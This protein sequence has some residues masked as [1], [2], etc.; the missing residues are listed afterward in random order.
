MRKLFVACLWLGCSDPKPPPTPQEPTE[1]DKQAP[2]IT[3][4]GIGEG[5]VTQA[6][7]TLTFSAADDHLKSVQGLLNGV[8]FASGSTVEREEDYTLVVDAVDASNNRSQGQRRFAIDRTAPVVRVSRPTAHAVYR[9][10]V[11][12]AYSVEEQHPKSTTLTWNGA[13]HT[14]PVTSEGDHVIRVA[15][16]DQAGNAAE[17]S[18]AFA[19][20]KTAPTLTVI[21]PP[22]GLAVASDSIQVLVRATDNRAVA[23]V[24]AG[25]IALALVGDQYAG[26][27]PLGLGRNSI[28]IVASD[29]AGNESSVSLIVVRAEAPAPEEDESAAPTLHV[30]LPAGGAI[31]R[32]VEVSGRVA[33]GTPPLVVTVNGAAAALTG[34]SF[35]H[36]LVATDGEATL[37]L[38]VTDARARSDRRTLTVVVDKTAPVITVTA[39]AENP[40]EIRLT[41]VVL[42]GTVVDTHLADFRIDGSPVVIS[43]LSTFS[44][45][46]DLAPGTRT[47]VLLARDAAGNKTTYSQVLHLEGRTPTVLLLSPFDGSESP[48]DRVEVRVRVASVASI[49]SVTM[50]GVTAVASGDTYVATVPL[51]LGDNEVEV[52]ATDI[53]GMVGALL[54][55]VHYSDAAVAPLAVKAV[56]P[57]QGSEGVAPGAT[58]ALTFNKPIE[59]SG[60]AAAISV[61][62]QGAPIA[63][64]L[65]VP[66]EGTFVTFS[67]QVPLPASGRVTVRV[68]ETL[69]AMTGPGLAAEFVSEFSVRQALTLLQGAMVTAEM[70]PIA[71][72][73]VTLAGQS[74]QTDRN[75][76]WIAVGAAGDQ[77]LTY[78]VDDQHHAF[79]RK[80]YVPLAETTRLRP[81]IMT[82]IDSAN[83]AHAAPGA[84][85]TFADALALDGSVVF[86]DGTSSGTL[87][88]TRLQELEVPFPVYPPLGGHRI[89]QLHPA[90][91]RADGPVTISFPADAEV[92]AGGRILILAL[93]PDPLVIKAI[94]LGTE[95]DGAIRSDE[96][97]ATPSLEAIG[98]IPLSEKAALLLQGAVPGDSEGALTPS[99]LRRMLG[100]VVKDAYAQEDGRE[101]ALLRFMTYGGAS[102]APIFA[103]LQSLLKIESPS[104][105]SGTV[106]AVETSFV[107]QRFTAPD[108]SRGAHVQ[109]GVTLPYSLRI[110]FAS[111]FVPSDP[112]TSLRADL[113]LWDPRGQP[114]APPAGQQWSVAGQEP[115]IDAIVTLAQAGTYRMSV[116]AEPE[117]RTRRAKMTGREY[118]IHVT[119]SA[120][121]TYRLVVA[122]APGQPLRSACSN[123]I[124][125]DLDGQSDMA[126]DGCQGPEDT[127]ES[128]LGFENIR[129]ELFSFVPDLWDATDAYG[130]YA[131]ATRIPSDDVT[132]GLVVAEFPLGLLNYEYRANDG[133][134][135]RAGFAPAYHFAKSDTFLLPP[136]AHTVANI[137]VD[138]RL[139][140]GSLVFVD[141]D[142]K[143]LPRFLTANMPATRYVDGELTEISAEDAK[144]TEIWFFRHRDLSQPILPFSVLATNIDA[145]GGPDSHG[146]YA[147]L[148]LGPGDIATWRRQ[149]KTETANT[150]DTRVLTEGERLVVF[151]VNH[152]TGH[153]GMSETVVPPPTQ[154][155]INA[156]V[157][158]YPPEVE[159]HIERGIR[160]GASAVTRQLVRHGGQ[161]T[162]RDAYVKVAT[163]WRVRWPGPTGY[164]DYRHNPQCTRVSEP[165]DLPLDTYGFPRPIG[166]A[167]VIV[168]P[169]RGYVK[170]NNSRKYGTFLL[171]APY[172]DLTSPV[173]RQALT[174]KEVVLSGR[175]V[176]GSA[177]YILLVNGALLTA[178]AQGVFSQEVP[179]PGAGEYAFRFVVLDA[180]GAKETASRSVTVL[181]GEQPSTFAQPEIRDLGP[182]GRPLEVYCSELHQR[183]RAALPCLNALDDTIAD[184]PRGVPALKGQLVEIGGFAQQ[185]AFAVPPGRRTGALYPEIRV[186]L[187]N[188]GLT[189]GRYYAHVVGHP[190]SRFDLDRDGTLSAAEATAA[191]DAG[192]DFAEGSTAAL[193]Q[194][195]LPLKNVYS[196]RIPGSGDLE[197][198]DLPRYYDRARE[199]EFEVVRV[200]EFKPEPAESGGRMDFLLGYVGAPDN[201]R[202][203][204]GAGAQRLWIGPNPKVGVDCNVVAEK[205][206]S[207]VRVDVSCDPLLLRAQ[208]R[209]YVYFAAAGNTANVVNALLV[210]W[211]KER[212]D[213]ASNRR[214]GTASASA[215]ADTISCPERRTSIDPNYLYFFL[216]PD[217]F[218]SGTVRV[219]LTDSCTEVLTSFDATFDE[220]R[221]RYNM[222]TIGVEQLSEA[223]APDRE[224]KYF[225]FR[226][227]NAVYNMPGGFDEVKTIFLETAATAP[228]AE[229]VL[230]EL[231]I[232][233][234]EFVNVGI[235]PAGQYT[236]GEINIA[237]GHVGLGYEDLSIP[238]RSGSWNFSR[239][240]NNQHNSLHPV[241][242]GWSHG[243]DSHLMEERMGE[244]YQVSAGGQSYDFP[245]CTP[246]DGH[247][248]CTGDGS[249]FGE[250]K[251]TYTVGGAA[252]GFHYYTLRGELLDETGNTWI[253]ETPAPSNYGGPYRALLT[254]VRDRRPA[255]IVYEY[256]ADADQ[257]TRIYRDN[258]SGDAAND[259][260]LTML[261]AYESI[262]VGDAAVGR[263]LARAAYERNFRL[264]QRVSV[265][266]GLV[267]ECTDPVDTV[268]LRHDTTPAGI[269]CGTP[270]ADGTTKYGLLTDVCRPMRSPFPHWT[271]SYL[272][273]PEA[274]T[275]PDLVQAFVNEI[276]RVEQYV[277]EVGATTATLY[278]RSVF[279]HHATRD[280]YLSEYGYILGGEIIVA[281]LMQGGNGAST[282]VAAPSATERIVTQP[283]GV[284]V[285]VTLDRWGY[286]QTASYPNGHT[287]TYDW[288]RNEATT[289]RIPIFQRA[290]GAM[291]GSTTVYE[292]SYVAA[293]P[294]FKRLASKAESVATSLLSDALPVYGFSGTMVSRFNDYAPTGEAREIVWPGPMSADVTT[295][296]V[297]ADTG[298]PISESVAVDSI[299]GTDVGWTVSRDAWGRQDSG[300]DHDGN[301]VAFFYD[302]LDAAGNPAFG[303]VTRVA[304]T[305]RL[306]TARGLGAIT[307]VFEYD[308]L[309][310]KTAVREGETGK[311]E[312]WG[313]DALDRKT[314]YVRWNT[315]TDAT[316]YTYRYA[317]SDEIS[318]GRRVEV[319]LAGQVLR[320]THSDIFGA[321]QREAFTFQGGQEEV[322][323]YTYEN[324]RMRTRFSQSRSETTTYNYSATNGWIE[325]VTRALGGIETTVTYNRDALGNVLSTRT[326]DDNG[327]ASVVNYDALGRPSGWDYGDGD[328]ETVLM[329][330]AGNVIERTFG[331]GHTIQRAY[332]AA[333]RLLSEAAKAPLADRINPESTYRYYRGGPVAAR[334]MG[335]TGAV[336]ESQ[337]EDVL[338]R[339][340]RERAEHPTLE[341]DGSTSQDVGVTTTT[342]YVDGAGGTE[343]Q[344]TSTVDSGDGRSYQVRQLQR[345]DAAGRP[346]E[347]IR[348][349]P[350]D[351]HSTGVPAL[352]RVRTTTEYNVWDK[353]NVTR[354]WYADAAA[355]DTWRLKTVTTHC[356]DEQGQRTWSFVDEEVKDCSNAA[357]HNAL[358]RSRAQ[359][360]AAGVTREVEEWGP[361][362]GHHA[363]QTFD[364]YG[365]A[366]TSWMAAYG[367]KPAAL[368]CHRYAGGGWVVTDTLQLDGGAA[369]SA[370]APTYGT[371]VTLLSRLRQRF[372]ARDLLIEEHQQDG[373]TTVRS[374][375]ISYDGQWPLTVTTREGTWL[376]QVTQ[377]DYDLLGAPARTVEAWQG[378]DPLHSYRYVTDRTF[379][380]RGELWRIE[381]AATWESQTSPEATPSRYAVNAAVVLDG[382][383]GNVWSIAYPTAGTELASFSLTDGAGRPTYSRPTNRLPVVSTYVEGVPVRT[384]L[385]D[386]VTRYYYQPYGP[387]AQVVNPLGQE[388]STEYSALLVPQSSVSDTARRTEMLFNSEGG[389]RGMRVYDASLA[390]GYAETSY[391]TGPGGAL[392]SATLPTGEVYTYRYT[393]DGLPRSIEA[394]G[395]ARS[396]FVYDAL[397]RV[398]QRIR[399]PLD[400]T[401]PAIWTFDYDE[402]VT[403]MTDPLGRQ[404]I[405]LTDGRGRT[406]EVAHVKDPAAEGLHRVATVFDGADNPRVVTE[407]GVT[408]GG[409]SYTAATSAAFDGALRTR[410]MRRV[411]PVSGD[412]TVGMAYTDLGAS[413]MVIA[414]TTPAGAI[415]ERTLDGLGNQVS[416][417]SSRGTATLGW[418]QSGL[419]LGYTQGEGVTERHCYDER[420]RVTRILSYTGPG[421]HDC[422]D[423][424][425]PGGL[426]VEHRYTYDERGNRVSQTIRDEGVTRYGFDRSDRLI[427]VRYPSGTAHLYSWRADSTR[428]GEKVIPAFPTDGDLAAFGAPAA[429]PSQHLQMSYDP[430]DGLSG[431]DDLLDGDPAGAVTTDAMGRVTEFA[432]G[433][434]TRTLV[435]DHSDR[436]L[437]VVQGGETNRYHYDA[438]GRRLQK[439]L[440]ATTR[441]FVWAGETLLEE[442]A[443][444]ESL[445]HRRAAGMLIG[446]GED[447]VTQDSLGSVVT[448]RGVDGVTD[449][450]RYDAWGNYQSGAPSSGNTTGYTGHTFDAE[451][452]LIYA[453]NRYLDPTLGRFLSRDPLDGDLASPVS[454]NPFSYANA[455][456]VSYIDPDGRSAQKKVGLLDA[457]LDIGR[458]MQEARVWAMPPEEKAKME[459]EYREKHWVANS[460]NAQCNRGDMISCGAL[461]EIYKYQ[462]VDDTLSEIKTAASVASLVLTPI[463]PGLSMA[464]GV[465][466]LGVEALQHP[467][468]RDQVARELAIMAVT[469]VGL[470]ALTKALGRIGTAAPKGGAFRGLSA[471]GRQLLGAQRR[472]SSLYSGASRS[473]T[474]VSGTPSRVG[475]AV[476]KQNALARQFSEEIEAGVAGRFRGPSSSGTTH[477]GLG[478]GRKESPG[479]SATELLRGHKRWNPEH[480][481]LSPGRIKLSHPLEP[482]VGIKATV[483]ERGIFEATIRTKDNLG[484]YLLNA[485]M[486]YRNAF[487]HF[488]SHGRRVQGIQ[489]VL[490]DEN[491]G[492]VRKALDLTP[493]LS[494]SE[495]VTQAPSYKHWLAEA[496]YQGRSLRIDAEELGPFFLVKGFFE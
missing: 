472:T 93:D 18:V 393:A 403:T 87:R 363:R 169:L 401:T 473:I 96:P 84:R 217:L 33:G 143:P 15:A 434:T 108:L 26:T 207:Q 6:V 54:L 245:C 122:P 399:R 320:T 53:D 28:P 258:Q 212:H 225:R 9:E 280:S 190:I 221:G 184:V 317:G 149:N 479:V 426:L 140:R 209:M 176:G 300:T 29:V 439:V 360:D 223:T 355:P 342:T 278:D 91:L 343:V 74:V 23:A 60:A 261:F 263:E 182:R 206:L 39:P 397:R 27:V 419:V 213:L 90:G 299:D 464:L 308:D 249:H 466:V 155:L 76:N 449:D 351:A 57:A 270:A 85:I 493:G 131:I 177:P 316:T 73:S 247:V 490:A 266:R 70:A 35:R 485:R 99:L 314:R 387:V 179:L 146:Q 81:V 405:S 36:S 102:V 443:A 345:L 407:I 113:S 59:R 354:L 16:E 44:H 453:V 165:L 142:G 174:E 51:S 4:T 189:T 238:E 215:L 421:I 413:G 130:Y 141:R 447:R 77:V 94:G 391:D 480:F 458:R 318:D 277:T 219:C 288:I 442:T 326:V 324:G 291:N 3:I 265:C 153:A 404:M 150:R 175:I 116:T 336:S 451:T 492:A 454:L 357:N 114:M 329:D 408:A 275:R 38:E 97:L 409:A 256:A 470:G 412:Y 356:F 358:Q 386:Q 327:R 476:D 361:H 430:L 5:R 298:G 46:L 406:V 154:L 467:E 156:D 226:I 134:P 251:V 301:A 13:A 422:A 83:R 463:A 339:P 158:L 385:G 334:T 104:L 171:G 10:D 236:A 371:G 120:G 468:S 390:A 340:T 167:D 181:P 410:E 294:A 133:D 438:G 37:E 297:I 173:D 208:D 135:T 411:D 313:L 418:E 67:P 402:G 136:G 495:A 86:A 233:P 166:E 338:N 183:F 240:Y 64:G 30:D 128:R 241:G 216:V 366:A 315:R 68:H 56:S 63:G 121:G 188:G 461:D 12:A 24:V 282:T 478:V 78:A 95:A 129:V 286:A 147:R 395:A 148:H 48:T 227:P 303:Q 196:A 109:E 281:S 290:M 462:A 471:E 112:D 47:F 237:S 445:T 328:T 373:E 459:A 100:L 231:D 11:T 214:A 229:S 425:V 152:R 440:G 41:P 376:T 444:G 204:I 367:T 465:S 302:A 432:F 168:D 71:G 436:L 450:H 260:L 107:T 435:W 267:T 259:G 246:V 381:T 446:I 415:L 117:D 455:N 414:E 496:Q 82:P 488:S 242:L 31:L 178:D 40:A 198:A 197:V 72:G 388:A 75:G 105:V 145:A 332:D 347:S 279:T 311:A 110:A 337:Y 289:A 427:G 201:S 456:P 380:R 157:K 349:V 248:E 264:L 293:V 377:S 34:R 287:V 89:W 375:T 396:E 378:G 21:A 254:R 43:S 323:T 69:A 19:I 448:R 185:I 202:A 305:F 362:P 119:S 160:S 232:P 49:G 115:S 353:P 441:T 437:R 257:V 348:Y 431:V 253:Y 352:A 424:G 186:T 218:E 193:P 14:G 469:T 452:G 276:E 255:D 52:L 321:A 162:T 2:I 346:I 92:P 284:R 222:S 341:V 163:H 322:V 304:T 482:E 124:D 22:E 42:R 132:Q 32:D 331:L 103:A 491:A 494:V 244:R 88:A 325:S 477:S 285:V 170:D 191:G 416:L 228:V 172:F 382:A 400:G 239:T 335:H 374:R 106:F 250:L 384:T 271:Y 205:T 1:E 268:V 187:Q 433:A 487:R 292:P 123:G 137:P 127:T 307:Q 350:Q 144:T 369:I 79:S 475:N 483:N 161:A 296:H 368:V 394:P 25:E 398:R 457:F 7:V 138:A 370:C 98:Y 211:V 484:N 365:R 423:A 200:R 428:L 8:A 65:H 383:G 392:Q 50:N 66:P 344:L 45:P 164:I 489:T 243:H 312:E 262:D 420:F 125:D 481:E 364:A 194:W 306:T 230:W 111:F 269:G 62:H 460:A 333:G 118:E 210:P 192:G 234:G 330:V 372:N 151:A 159:M 61:W 417:A 199:H 486:L 180:C 17:V 273:V 58:I 474:G 195:A 310:R 309:G 359:T 80:V 295:R 126:D 379:E 101:E 139:L 235:R 283:D 274:V 55:T 272:P 220:V 429:A 224:P 203:G 319:L 20:D 252:R 389:P